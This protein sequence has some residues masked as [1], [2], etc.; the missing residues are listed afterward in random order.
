MAAKT[1]EPMTRH[2]LTYAKTVK[3]I[4]KTFQIIGLAVN[5]ANVYWNRSSISGKRKG[6]GRISA[7]DEGDQFVEISVRAAGPSTA[8]AA[9]P[10][11]ARAAG[12]NMTRGIY[13]FAQGQR[14][15]MHREDLFPPKKRFLNMSL[16]LHNHFKLIL[17]QW[18][19]HGSIKRRMVKLHFTNFL[20]TAHSEILNDRY[21]GYRI[22]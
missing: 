5:P 18:W 11:I 13:A 9:G 21:K 3:Y 16:F 20:R 4:S 6:Y 1:I 12:P 15:Y 22:N 10:I 2:E 19:H 8:R 7:S 17:R 14:K